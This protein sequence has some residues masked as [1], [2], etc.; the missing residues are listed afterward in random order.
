M[1]TAIYKKGCPLENITH[2]RQG[3]Q[4]ATLCDK[5]QGTYGN[6][7]RN[8]VGVF[9]GSAVSALLLIIYFGG[10]MDDYRALN[11]WGK[12]P[13]RK[14]Q[15][16]RPKHRKCTSE[17]STTRTTIACNAWGKRNHQRPPQNHPAEVNNQRNSRKTHQT[18]ENN[19]QKPKS[20]K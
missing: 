11:H 13:T 16:R 19:R 9:Q 15:Q 10:M 8:N 5:H 20:R 7:V 14:T 6:P 1:R 4:N 2:I 17:P 18:W 3:H 12:L